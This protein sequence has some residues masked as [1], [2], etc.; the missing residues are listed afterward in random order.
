MK[1]LNKLGSALFFIAIAV[2]IGSGVLFSEEI[3]KEIDGTLISVD[4]TNRRLVVAYEIPATGE[5]KKMEFEV[6]DG[7]GFKDFKKLSQLKKGDL[8]SVDYLDYKPL[9][10]A[11]YIVRIP[12][13]KTFFTHKEVTEA[14]VKI[15]TNQKSSDVAKN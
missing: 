3:P 1:K 14:L 2:F 9:P 7:A 8:V 13:E 6:G 11:V 4:E 10:K 5:H 15:K 12:I